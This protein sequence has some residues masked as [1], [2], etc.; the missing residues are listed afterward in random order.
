MKSHEVLKATMEPLGVKF[1]ASEMSLSAQLIYK[2]LQDEYHTGAC[3]NP[4]D[5]V[6]ELYQITGDSNI[7]Q[8][9]CN[10]AGGYFVE[11]LTADTFDI[12]CKFKLTKNIIKEFG[13]MLT[14][15]TDS[16]MDGVITP[17]EAQCIRKEWEDLKSEAEKFVVACE[18]GDYK[19]EEKV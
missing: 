14:A 2:W 4:L 16:K 13:E 11:N 6:A 19:N 5:R 9:L 12:E 3:A 10:Q 18:R 7:I 8:W 17:K 15:I 1:I